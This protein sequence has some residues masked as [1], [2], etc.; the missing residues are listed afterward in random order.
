MVTRRGDPS[1]VR[2]LVIDLF[3]FPVKESLADL[4]W[5]P[6]GCYIL[7]MAKVPI[8]RDGYERLYWQL[9]YLLRESRREVRRA[10]AAARESGLTSR[11]LEWRTAREKQH[12][13]ESRIRQLSE[14]MAQ[15]EVFLTP[16]LAFGRVG[17]GLF[18]EVINILTGHAQV[19]QMVG[20][21]ESD[22]GSG[23]LSVLS[24]VGRRLLGRRVGEK[25]WIKCPGGLSLYKVIRIF[26]PDSGEP[27]PILGDFTRYG[28]V[29]L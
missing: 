4:A 17:F 23:R 18:V 16:P 20:P 3:L 1:F 13:V 6:G 2:I 8:T 11:N 24:P 7:I 19:F 9:Q 5:P 27:E 12:L 14:M 15:C 26:G 21:Y 28:E 10:L 25:V 29:T 22:V